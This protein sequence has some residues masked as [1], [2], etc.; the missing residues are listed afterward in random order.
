MLETN[1]VGRKCVGKKAAKL[2]LEYADE[3]AEIVA[4][5]NSTGGP[6]QVSIAFAD[7]EVRET[8]LVN[9][10]LVGPEAKKAKKEVTQ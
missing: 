7:G 5:F 8:F 9:V 4:V 3:P 1:L 10:T 2:P 6:L